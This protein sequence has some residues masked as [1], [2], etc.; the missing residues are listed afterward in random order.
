MAFGNLAQP[1]RPASACSQRQRPASA[2][3]QRP[4]RDVS[5]GS[6]ES[7]ASRSLTLNEREQA[8]QQG[9]I[10][11]TWVPPGRGGPSNLSRP[12]SARSQRPVSAGRRLAAPSGDLEEEMQ[13]PPLTLVPHALA[14]P[15][16]ERF[17]AALGLRHA[18][19]VPRLPTDVEGCSSGGRCCWRWLARAAVEQINGKTISNCGLGDAIHSIKSELDRLRMQISRLEGNH[20]E[21]VSYA[22]ELAKLRAVHQDTLK[23]LGELKVVRERIEF[24]RAEND[25]LRETNKHLLVSERGFQKMIECLQAQQTH[26]VN[27]EVAALKSRAE[28]AELKLAKAEF[29][30]EELTRQ[31]QKSEKKNELDQ[32]EKSRLQ[33]QLEQLAQKAERQ[34]RR[35]RRYRSGSPTY[36][37]GYRR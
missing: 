8:T 2:S 19:E 14:T 27:T 23:E 30:V 7:W 6:R 16:E 24:V 28:E 26:L 15:L 21:G 18:A 10:R 31:L 34:A 1:Q 35:R 12:G 13:Q 36:R 5:P 25:D 37:Y 20:E 22:H 11:A 17:A 4:V 33:R 32:I 29:E 9:P 3:S